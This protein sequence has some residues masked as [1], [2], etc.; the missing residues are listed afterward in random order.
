MT[1]ADD[2]HVYHAA[3]EQFLCSK[4]GVHVNQHAVCCLALAGVTGESVA[5]IEMNVAV[6]I[7]FDPPDAGT[8]NLFPHAWC[9]G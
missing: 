2:S 3:V 4:V 6:W 5:V 1:P 9:S 8:R 7:E